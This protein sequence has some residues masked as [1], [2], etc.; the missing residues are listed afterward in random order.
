MAEQFELAQG[1]EERARELQT[2]I[3]T[4]GDVQ[5]EAVGIPDV[6]NAWR[7]VKPYW[8]W[9]ITIVGRIPRVGGA[10]AAALTL[11]GQA[12]DTFCPQS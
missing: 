2:A 10:I 4:R 8:P 11:I 9:I 7:K 12:L 6:C 3:D 1:D 5:K